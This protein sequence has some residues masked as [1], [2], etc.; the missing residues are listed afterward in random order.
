[1]RTAVVDTKPLKVTRLP[2]NW[3]LWAQYAVAIGAVGLALLGRLLIEAIVGSHMPFLTSFAALLVLVFLVR[4]GPFIAAAAL[5]WIV[6][7]CWLFP[8]WGES[9]IGDPVAVVSTAL[10]GIVLLAIIITAM[11]AART[12]RRADKSEIAFHDARKNLEIVTDTVGVAVAH[13]SADLRYLWVNKNCATFLDRHIEDIIGK[14]IRDVLGES[15]MHRIMPYIFRVLDGETVEFE[16]Q[17]D[18]EKLG[19]RF[20]H[21]VYT[22]VYGEDKSKP[23]GWVAAISDITARKQ[24][25]RARS[26]LAAVAQTSQDAII[27]KTLDGTITSWNDGAEQIFGYTADEMIGKSVLTLLPDDKRDE[28]EDIIAMISRG[29]RV[30]HFESVRITKDGRRI[31][32]SLSIAPIHD[33]KGR[34]VGAAKVLRDITDQARA[35]AALRES[36]ERFSKFMQHLPGLAWIKDAQ[37]RYVFANDAAE[38]AFQKTRDHLYGRSD[39][40]IFDKKTA[41]Q[42][43]SNDQKVLETGHGVETIETL[44]HD[45]GV[46]HHSLVSKFPIPGSDGK[47]PL[48]GGMAID[49]T[50]RILAERALRESEERYRRLMGLLPIAVY[51]CSAPD[52]KITFY[53]EHAAHL[54]G[55]SPQL[56][57]TDQRFCG[58]FKLFHPDG[59][60]LPHEKTPMAV[61]IRTGKQF[62]NEEV[63]IE[64][65]DESRINV[66]V[67]IDPIHDENGRLVGAINA[68][69]DVTELRRARELIVEQRRILEM[70]ARGEPRDVCLRELCLSA[71]R[72]DTSTRPCVMIA[73]RTNTRLSRVIAPHWQ[74]FADNLQQIEIAGQ[75]ASCAAVFLKRE[76]II[77]GDIAGDDRIPAECKP[78]FLDHQVKAVLA[79]PIDSGADV[80]NA[81]MVLLFDVVKQPTEWDHRVLEM[82]VDVAGILLR[83]DS[84]DQ[85]LRASHETLEILN[86]VGATLS[87]E[88]NTEKLIQ[89]VTD[90]GTELSGAKFGAFFFNTVNEQGEAL[91]L[92]TLS[93][94][95]REAFEKF[96]IPRNT[97]IFAPT[98]SGEDIV[99]SDD[100][101]K[102]P[103]Y[104]TMHPHHG[105]PKGH[106]P[107][108]SYLAVP[109]ISRTGT[110]LG[111]LFFGHPEVGVFTEQSEKLIG[112]IAAQAAIALDNAKLYAESRESEERFRALSENLPQLAWM[113]QP[114]GYIFWYNRRW[115]DYTGTTLEQMQGWGWQAVH[116]PDHVDRVTERFKHHLETGEPWEDT[117]P[118]R[119]KDGTF[120]WFLSRAFPIRNTEGQITRWFGTNT[121]I[122]E[123]LDAQAAVSESEEQFRRAIEDAPIPILMHAEDGEVLQISRTWTELTGYTLEHADMIQSWLTE[124]Y[125][126]G[127]NE[128]RAAVHK[129]FIDDRF[130]HATEYEITTA[131]GEN[132]TWALH[133]SS[134]GILRDGRRFVVVMAQDITERKNA[135]DMLRK[136]RAHLEKLVAERTVE[137]EQSF[138][139][140]REAERYATIGTLAAGLGHDLSNLILPMSM[141]ADLLRREN[142]SEAARAEV[143]AIAASTNYLKRLATSLRHLARDPERVSRNDS[144][145]D[146]SEWCSNVSPLFAAMAPR[147]TKVECSVE[148]DPAEKPHNGASLL[149]RIDS[150]HLTQIVFN[151]VQN[152][153]EAITTTNRDNGLIEVRGRAVHSSQKSN[154]GDSHSVEVIVRDNGPGMNAETLAKINEPYFTTK[155]HSKAGGIGLTM[156]RRMIENAGGI[157]N[158]SSREG[159]GTV[160]T[161]RLQCASGFG[162]SSQNVQSEKHVE[163]QRR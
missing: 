133:A 80:P 85:S 88:L 117:F 43:L 93:G 150:A 125:G 24:L 73:D 97:P 121:D 51:T 135:E 74:K 29:E 60:P 155:H 144:V 132:R 143:D 78:A 81:S 63:V 66:I 104:G 76:T 56:N 35:Q 134:P 161:I 11:L 55:R 98:F 159:E 151:L 70:I 128:L 112:G 96:G 10:F 64:R 34:V 12:L 77:A 103:R 25:E 18:Y 4:L 23:V 79:A 1:M 119:G 111:G 162:H 156:V 14:P 44:K 54:W 129:L 58:S 109:V 72:L 146:L 148:C 95:P 126:H 42:F 83:R 59:T 116:H 69:H 91:L 57:D 147:S 46:T 118:L 32:V 115:Y 141:G 27:S 49:V 62:R 53:N 84:A 102:D 41:G 94:A 105:M 90:A 142:I 40:E 39:E 26:H 152:A 6:A 13:C 28:E 99:R 17:L 106:L 87:A 30:N 110:V 123:L 2:L 154:N 137:L 100:I 71:E 31:N 89:S 19:E 20:I 138:R 160:F 108:R 47:T 163:S 140:L 120:R 9:R 45:D 8:W 82:A 5:E 36:E 50:D 48:I 38:H 114:D 158:I 127:G 15:A 65:E 153:A 145:T 7:G 101:T 21:A 130:V 86:E 75:I 157:L 92:Y 33:D 122:T 149:A 16:T 113:T 124:A 139:R 22:P 107:V 61:A 67:N 3:P 37:G 68:F 136:H 131:L 52:G